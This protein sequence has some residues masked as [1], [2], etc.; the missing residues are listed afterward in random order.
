MSED[1]VIYRCRCG[2][3][4]TINH[5]PFSRCD[6]GMIRCTNGCGMVRPEFAP[7]WGLLPANPKAYGLPEVYRGT[8]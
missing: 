2:W 8:S 4:E 1:K 3:T 7:D 6:P 5:S